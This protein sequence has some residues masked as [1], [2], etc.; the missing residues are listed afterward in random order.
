MR[1]SQLS[2]PQMV[3]NCF[4]EL[5]LFSEVLDNPALLLTLVELLLI[6]LGVT[7][8]RIGH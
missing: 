4:A 2:T 6:F 1:A 8:R 7:E 5:G 3:H